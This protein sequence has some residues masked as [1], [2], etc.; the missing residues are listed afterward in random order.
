MSWLVILPFELI[1]A[2]VTISFWT[3]NDVDEKV[4]ITPAAWITIFL[5]LIIIVNVFGVRGYG[6]VEFVLGAI[7]VIAVIGFII[8]G[9]VI[10]VGGVPTDNR[11]VVTLTLPVSIQSL[12]A[13]Q[14]IHR[15]HLLEISTKGRSSLSTI[16]SQPRRRS[17]NRRD[18]TQL[19]C[20]QERI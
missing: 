1:A 8:M 18:C 9:I 6:E 10:N 20:F 15:R 13:I 2:G 14:R 11:F 12:T 5:V 3:G 7:K 17:A 16:P 19:V 4:S